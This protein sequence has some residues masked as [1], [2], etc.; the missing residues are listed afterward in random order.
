MP[1]TIW[2]SLLL[3]GDFPV[4]GLTFYS[5]SAGHPFII[6]AII[7]MNW[8]SIKKNMLRKMYVISYASVDWS[9]DARSIGFLNREHKYLDA[10]AQSLNKDKLNMKHLPSWIT[11]WFTHH[12]IRQHFP[13]FCA[14]KLKG[15]YGGW[16]HVK[17]MDP[18]TWI[19]FVRPKSSP[20]EVVTYIWLILM[21]CN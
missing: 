11:G 19:V 18:K 13:F 4:F 21:R 15:E 9:T 7:S 6:P 2:C 20:K 5:I 8:S 1:P 17:I 16:I 14:T 12:T 3:V 10:H